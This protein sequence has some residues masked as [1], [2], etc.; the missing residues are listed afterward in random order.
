M[1]RRVIEA[2]RELLLDAA[3]FLA[4]NVAELVAHQCEN[5]N[6]ERVA[7]QQHEIDDRDGDSNFSSPVSE[8]S[9]S[10]EADQNGGRHCDDEK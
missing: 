3:E 10:G 6:V 2:R 7:E 8:V 4:E 9:K 5:Q 1:I